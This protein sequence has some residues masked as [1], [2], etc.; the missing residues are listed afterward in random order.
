M[1]IANL[2]RLKA[3]YESKG[4]NK[5]LADVMKALVAR[6]VQPAPAAVEEP[7]PVSKKKGK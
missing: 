6:G 3:H 4:M 2:E 5:Q 1:T 7:K